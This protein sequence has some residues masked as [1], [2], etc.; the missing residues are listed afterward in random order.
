MKKT[1]KT[2]MGPLGTPLGNPLGYFNSQ[3]AKRSAPTK[4][5]LR[6]AQDG[7]AV[8]P[9][10]K[11]TVEY[12]DTKYPGTALKFQGPYSNDYMDNQREKVAQTY[13]AFSWGT[14]ADLEDTLRKNEEN[15]IRSWRDDFNSGTG[16]SKADAYRKGGSVKKKPIIKKGGSVKKMQ[17]GGPTYS[18]ISNTRG[19]GIVKNTSTIGGGKKE[20][21]KSYNLG[22]AGPSSAKVTVRKYDNQGDL[23]NT[24]SRSTTP[25]KVDKYVAKNESKISYKKGGTTRKVT[26]IKRKK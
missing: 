21:E 23:K 24:R 26:S 25:E 14:A 20:K 4:Q 19:V 3:K 12:L 9:M 13:D 8:G 22:Y 15:Q 18:E 10:E 7:R 5:N 16:L 17:K 11:G 6:K 1:T 2:K